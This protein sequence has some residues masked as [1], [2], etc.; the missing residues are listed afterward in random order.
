MKIWHKDLVCHLADDLLL[1]LFEN[2]SYKYVREYCNFKIK[3]LYPEFKRFECYNKSHFYLY[4]SIII[5]EIEKREIQ[6]DVQYYNC[7]KQFVYDFVSDEERQISSRIEKDN[8]LFYGWHNTRYLLQCYYEL[9]FLF[10]C[11]L[12]SNDNWVR[13]YQHVKSMEEENDKLKGM[14]IL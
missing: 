2:C 14:I 12:I 11:G 8:S 9:Q 13:L 10:D 6:D 4:C 7:W 1:E 3:L 5:N